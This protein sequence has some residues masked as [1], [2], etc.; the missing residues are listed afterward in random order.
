MCKLFFKPE[1][2]PF[3]INSLRKYLKTGSKFEMPDHLKEL[4]KELYLEYIEQAVPAAKFC[5]TKILKSEEQQQQIFLEG[6]VNFQGKGIYKL[7][8]QSDYAAIYCLTIGNKLEE[9][10]SRMQT[11]DF[12]RS[13]VLDSIAST[14]VSGLHDLLEIIISKSANS[15]DRRLTKRFSPGYAGWKLEEQKKLFYILDSA[16]EENKGQGT[17]DK[18][19]EKDIGVYLTEE[20][21]MVPGKSVSGIYGFCK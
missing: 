15:L 14:L 5:I 11:E 8:R 6:N 13:Y 21:Y 4:V 12:Y 1:E 17:A 7:L 20:C 9:T 3:D 19:G 18:G 2:I 16:E 10:I